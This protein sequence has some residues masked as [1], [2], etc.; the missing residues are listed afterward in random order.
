MIRCIYNIEL[1]YQAF[2][3]LRGNRLR[4]FLSVLGITIGIAAVIT[5]GTIS[6]GGQLLIFSEL[7]TFGLKSAWVY[8]K[9]DSKNPNEYVRQGTGID[10]TDVRILESALPE[11][12]ARLTPVV[13]V[14]ER[15]TVR[16]RGRFS[17]AQIRGVN[18]HF[19]TITNDELLSGRE[20]RVDEVRKRR[21]LAVIGTLVRDDLFGVNQDPIGKVFR[22]A[23][24]QFTVI[25][26]LKDKSRDFLAS[27]GTVGGQ[28]ANNRIVIPYTVLQ[29]FSGNDAVNYLQLEA[30]SIERADNAANQVAQLLERQHHSKY[31]Y[32]TETMAQYIATTKRI[33]TGVTLIGIVTASVSLLVGGLGIMNIMSTSVIERTR[34]IGLRKA[35]GA[36]DRDILF[37]FLM[38][39]VFV[40]VVG[41]AAGLLLGG[42]AS[43]V[44]ATLSDF[45]LIPSWL[46]VAAAIVVSISVGLASGYYPAQRAARMNPVEALRYE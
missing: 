43:W 10:N 30:V 21:K 9:D 35:V 37:Q 11:T 44:L 4:T 46:N 12:V 28:S 13:A 2:E 34:E 6:K 16:N 27:I 40:S 7:E 41:G 17:N 31:Q 45:P 29:Q 32:Q 26:L 14:D 5:V 3:A 18:A 20:F 19:F 33:M 24:Q 1:V 23:E 15:L 25:G 39:A 36:Q 22:I 38:E 8:R 42:S